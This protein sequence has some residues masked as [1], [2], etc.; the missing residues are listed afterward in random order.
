MSKGKHK[1]KKQR[2]EQQA[3]EQAAA[4]RLLEDK[5][6]SANEETEPSTTR[7]HESNNNDN[8]SRWKQF[9]DWAKQNS[10]FT[11][12]CIALF[13]FVLAGAAIYQ[14]VIMGG[15]LDEMRKGERPWISISF[16]NGT[17]KTNAPISSTLSIVNKGKTPARTITADVAIDAVKNG[18][19]P[20]LNYPLPHTRFTTGLIFPGDPY[21]I[22]I[23][24]LRTSNNGGPPEADLLTQPAFDDFQN[25]RLFFVLYA[26]V[27]YKD[28][29]GIEHWTRICAAWVQS[30]V[31]G[32]FTGQ[33]CTNYGDVDSN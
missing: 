17:L 10:S 27:S 33:K 20:K 18:E 6:M 16:N 19:E 22:Q 3:K 8:P 2:A 29:F 7:E 1:R 30:R 28:F 24:K 9:R 15:Q 32:S 12:W 5:K 11:D 31:P 21:T 13:T 23:N 4:M 26:N 25:G 14:F